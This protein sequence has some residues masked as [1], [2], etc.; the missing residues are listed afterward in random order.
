MRRLIAT[1]LLATATPLAAA[2]SD[3][4]D[5]LLKE[6]WAWYLANNPEQATA[7]GVHDNDT[8]LSDVSL[9]AADRQAAEAERFRTRL[10]AIPDAGLKTDERVNKAILDRL[11][12][13]QIEGNRFGERQMLFTTYYGWHQGFAGLADNLSFQRKTDYE[14]YLARLAA[15]PTLNQ[16]A[17][18]ITRAAV[19]EGYAQPCSAIRGYEKTIIGVIAPDP[20]KSRF[21]APFAGA[22]PADASDAEWAALQ[23][24]AKT[25]ITGTVEPEYRRFHDYFTREYL[26][27]CRATDGAS[28]MPRGAEWY[29][30]RARALTTTDATPEQIHQIGLKEVAR[31]RAE[32]EAVARQ[33]G[34]ASREAMI[35]ELRT[36]PK[37]YARNA[38]E[39]LAAAALQAK[40]IDGM[41]PKYFGLMP[42]LPYGVKPI[43]AEIAEGTTTAFY[44]AGSPPAGIAGTYYVNTS[45]LPQRPLWE[46]PALTAHESV[47][48]H[49]F[50]IALQQELPLPEF[51]RHQASFTAF[52]EGWAL[53]TERLGIEMGLYDTPEKQMGRLS[54]EMWRACRLVVDTGIHVKGWTKAQAVTFMRENTALTD[55]NI[56]AEVNRYI[57]WPAQA[58][59][60]K[61]GELK[62][63][64]LRARAE[65]VLGP[66]FDLRR[67]HD[68]V[69]GQGAVPLDVLE[70]QIDAWIA[71]EKARG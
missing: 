25:L 23:A 13:E 53:Y 66:K 7:L 56:D 58:L 50:Q 54:Y 37:Y 12:T 68:A 3:D 1:L 51:R 46:L 44:G 15:Y 62:I 42:R 69:L 55:A 38:E 35:A 48:G 31:I 18:R 39:L 4:L 8:K 19:A 45:K 61:M 57:S 9:A 34:F 28:A 43:P 49:H 70:T 21:Y 10:R 26:P 30:Y 65:T 20:T 16:E 67:F 11:L 5:A 27:K 36:N 29:A 33:A 59:G 24:R 2:P 6:H 41:L 64:D 40:R 32:M 14:S 22:K 17:I 63:R 47:P 60:Y 52:V 71:A